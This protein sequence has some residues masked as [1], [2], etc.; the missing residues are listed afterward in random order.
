M[1]NRGYSICVRDLDYVFHRN[2]EFM[3]NHIL[4][5]GK[6]STNDILGNRGIDFGDD[7][8]RLMKT[9]KAC[10]HDI[11]FFKKLDCNRQIE[12]RMKEPNEFIEFFCTS[13]ACNKLGKANHRYKATRAEQ[14]MR[15][16]FYKKCKL[17][18][19]PF[20][21]TKPRASAAVHK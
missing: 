14:K 7:Y 6:I 11:N 2:I 20:D 21:S 15:L 19:K 9:M 17:K 10:A 13:Y 8:Y 12:E 16:K 4:I 5:V 18:P 3:S 1:S